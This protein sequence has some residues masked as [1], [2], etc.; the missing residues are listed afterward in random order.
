MS[1][2]HKEWSEQ[3]AVPLQLPAGYK[4]LLC[5]SLGQESCCPL[6]VKLV[7]AGTS[8]KRPGFAQLACWA[9]AVPKPPV[10]GQRWKESC[11]SLLWLQPEKFQSKTELFS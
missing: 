3:G 7:P 1:P 6:M 8:D 4:L 2:Q 9:S 11:S 10:G 5:S